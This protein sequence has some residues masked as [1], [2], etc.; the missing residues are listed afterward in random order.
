MKVL[1]AID[2]HFERDANGQVHLGP[3]MSIPGSRFWERYLSAFEEVVV[4]ARVKQLGAGP[5]MLAPACG[6]RVRFHD[7]PDYLGPWQYLQ[8]LRVLRLEVESAVRGADAFVLRVPGAI[9]Q[10]AWE[11]LRRLGRPYA[12]EVVADPWDILSP[13][14]TRSSVRPI[15]R[16]LWSKRLRS[17]CVEAAAVC[18]VTEA[19][20]QKRYPPGRHT[21]TTFASD[22]DIGNRLAT[23]EELHERHRRLDEALPGSSTTGRRIRIGFLGAMAQMYKSPDILLCAAAT[24]VHDGLDCEVEM[25]GDG[26]YRRMLQNLAADLGIQERVRFLGALPPGENVW[27]FL[28]GLDLFVLPSRQE[29]LPRAMVEAMA[30]G[31]PCIG[32]TVGGIPELL[33][34]ADLVAPGDA[35]QLA[36]KIREI[37]SVRGRMKIMSERNWKKA[38]DYQPAVLEQRR[39]AFYRKVRELGDQSMKRPRHRRSQS[40]DKEKSI[41]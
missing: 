23:S 22:V 38:M 26:K 29:G 41:S 4:L 7:L 15:M 18:Y 40:M 3:P 13:G 6:P 32:S 21:W 28:D 11:S 30:R 5:S 34:T 25:A 17:M 37:L 33:T 19:A 12:L 39:L 20:L 8:N 24:C 2:H 14:A 9:G 27:R 31:C 1:V 10:L 16:R 35:D 36:A